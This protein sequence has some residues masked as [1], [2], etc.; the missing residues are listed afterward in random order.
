MKLHFDDCYADERLSYQKDAIEV[1]CYLFGGQEICRSEFTV[2]VDQTEQLNR[3][4]QN[5]LGIGNQLSLL[6]D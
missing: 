2:I 6:D 3:M 4:S 1:V 5:Q